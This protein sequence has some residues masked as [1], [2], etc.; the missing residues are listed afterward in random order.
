[1]DSYYK[2]LV[3]IR[4]AHRDTSFGRDRD[5]GLSEKG[6][7]QTK[8]ILKYFESRFEGEIPVVMSSPK[9]RCVETIAL[10]AKSARVELEWSPLLLEHGESKVDNTPGG[11]QKRVREF[12]SWWKK[13]GPELLVVCSHGDWIPLVVQML[14]GANLTLKKGGWVEFESTNEEIRLTWVLQDFKFLK[15]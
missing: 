5:N 2:T 8:R 1:M 13:E 7:L 14:S 15:I 10:I 11:F 9:N 12:V 4:H 3:I 6:Q